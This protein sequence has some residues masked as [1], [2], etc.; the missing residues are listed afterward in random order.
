MWLLS[1]FTQLAPT[2]TLQ[3][4]I[5]HHQGEP[6]IDA[7]PTTPET[8]NL[9]PLAY[10]A[11]RGK[12]LTVDAA[13]GLKSGLDAAATVS[14]PAGQQALAGSTLQVNAADGS[15]EFTPASTLA[16]GAL[17]T[18][19][20]A[21][22]LPTPG[23]TAARSVTINVLA[24]PTSPLAA[25]PV[26]LDG[27][28]IDWQGGTATPAITADIIAGALTTPDGQTVTGAPAGVELEFAQATRAATGR[29]ATSSKKCRAK[30]PAVT[31]SASSGVATA[32]AVPCVA[33]GRCF[34]RLKLAAGGRV[35]VAARANKFR[36]GG[37]SFK[38]GAFSE[39]VP[40][41]L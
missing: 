4:T 20:V 35:L 37:R 41:D 38:A 34:K 25:P 9:A 22:Q 30:L 40:V 8:P 17:V 21:V 12:T 13:S 6:P 26:A 27:V 23:V 11:V 5:L 1:L 24:S 18:F 39:P 10:A 14:V 15:F 31:V 33:C 19:D 16:A 36:A 32:K 29:A 3:N 2:T 7:A 28:T